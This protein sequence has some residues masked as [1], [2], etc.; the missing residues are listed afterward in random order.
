MM[1]TI[2]PRL[3]CHSRSRPVDAFVPPRPRQTEVKQRVTR[4]G[5]RASQCC[6]AVTSRIVIVVVVIIVIVVVVIVVVGVVIGYFHFAA[7]PD[8]LGCRS[9]HGR[10]PRGDHHH[11]H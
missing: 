3:L 5:W 6:T 1:S 11:R 4:S 2:V 9:R 10:S 7:R 8:V